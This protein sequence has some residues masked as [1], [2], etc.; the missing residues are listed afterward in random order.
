MSAAAAVGGFPKWVLLEPYVF[1]RDDDESFP[2]ESE[3]PI[4][5]SGTTSWGADF[6]IAFSL[7]EPPHISRLYA[8]LPG[9]PGPHEEEPLIML[10]THRHLALLVVAT[11]IT[12]TNTTII[13][14]RPSKPLVQNFFIFR[15][16]ENNPSSS[17]LRLLPPCTEPKFDYCRSDHRL[18][19][20]PSNVTPTPRLLNMIS[21]GL[22]CGDKEEF[23]V[24]ELTLYVPTIDRSQTKAFADIC[25]LRSSSTDDQLGSKWDSWR[26][27]IMSPHNPSADDLL[28]L[29]RWQT[30]AVIPFKKWLCWI[31]YNR[32]ILFCD[33][34]DKVRAPTVSFLWF[35][36]DKS[37]LTRARKATSGTIGGVSVIDHGRLLKFV[38]VARHDGRAYGALQ[39][40][41]GFTITCHTLVLG[42][43]MAWKED[44]TVTSDDLPD[45]YR[46]GI[47]IH[48]QVDIDWPHVVHF[49]FIEFGKAYEKMS[50][51]SIDMSTKTVKS[52]YLYV[53][54]NEILHDD[55]ECLQPDDDIDFIRSTSLYPTPLPFLP[56]EFPT[57]CYLSRYVILLLPFY[58]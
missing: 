55:K 23:V 10:A 40:G 14:P 3:A 1:R 25:L 45:R 12:T 17:S 56:C 36:E 50:V 20:R 30:T 7:E 6:R 5:A 37:P 16:N 48:P 28:E 49:L 43:S 39:P 47:P 21:L 42:G 26:V 57:F 33:V 38:N 9:F 8:Q 15:A 19:R 18:S 31:D 4:R 35:P 13:T 29:S 46:R 22:W 54:G 24:A 41:T 51:L 11:T 52:F 53:D 58:K 2:D 34:S 32:G 44:Y 27:T